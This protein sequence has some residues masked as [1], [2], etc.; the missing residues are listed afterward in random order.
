MRPAFMRRTPPRLSLVS[1]WSPHR[2]PIVSPRPPL[3]SPPP[4]AMI[5][6]ERAPP[7]LS[8]ELC[9]SSWGIGDWG[10]DIG[11]LGFGFRVRG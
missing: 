3:V 10:L 9:P 5:S 7:P 11:D 6:R 4:L 8:T 1:L 2:L